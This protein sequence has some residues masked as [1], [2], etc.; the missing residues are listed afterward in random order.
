LFISIF[1]YPLVVYVVD[2]AL[3]AG[4]TAAGLSE[5]NRAVLTPPYRDWPLIVLKSAMRKS[6]S[7][8]YLQGLF[9]FGAIYELDHELSHLRG[10]LIVLLLSLQLLSGV[11]V[12]DNPNDH[13]I[14]AERD[15][16]P[17]FQ[18]E[19]PFYFD[20]CAGAIP[21]VLQQVGVLLV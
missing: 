12:D 19:V 1:E 14:L 4:Q 2:S 11:L 7:G 9:G 10:S 17:V 18:D 15:N 3:Y 16:V 20:E 8:N 13:V 6:F 5:A 21:Q